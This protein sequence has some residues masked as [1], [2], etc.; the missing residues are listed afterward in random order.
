MK[1]L[2]CRKSHDMTRN[3]CLARPINHAHAKKKLAIMLRH[4]TAQVGPTTFFYLARIISHKSL[5]RPN[6][7]TWIGGVIGA[8][9][10][11]K[12]V[13]TAAE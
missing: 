1:F 13:K 6:F 9:S 3:E 12:L 4:E 10:A 5:A 7:V 8:K 11:S 2:H